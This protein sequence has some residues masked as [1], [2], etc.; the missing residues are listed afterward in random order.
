[1][2]ALTQRGIRWLVLSLGLALAADVAVFASIL[3]FWSSPSLYAEVSLPLSTA[4][5]VLLF[6]C[7]VPGFLGFR[8]LRRVREEF[9]PVPRASLR[10]GTAAFIL[11]GVAAVLFTL[12][13]IFLGLFYIP[14]GT[15]VTG[16]TYSS[17]LELALGETLRT[18]HVVAPPVIAVFLGL[19][20]IESIWRL[21]TRSIRV[22]AVAALVSGV[23]V[24]ILTVP[25]IGAR[26]YAVLGLGFA[27]LGLVSA[28][29]LVLWIVVLLFVDRRL[30]TWAP[31]ASPRAGAS[32]LA[33]PPPPEEPPAQPAAP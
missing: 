30:R 4:Y 16:T 29:S 23:L 27:L 9:G 26:V 12:T 25:P 15:Y 2:C 18:V 20:L 28:A 17:S 21:A 33:T 10:R 1:M 14:V 22:L 3:A 6:V 24:P 13:G 32:R 11:G 19:F 7:A 31:D 8:V 5:V